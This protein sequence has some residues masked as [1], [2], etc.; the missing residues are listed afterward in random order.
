MTSVLKDNQKQNYLSDLCQV[1]KKK[2]YYELIFKNNE[3][4][5]LYIINDEIFRL[6]IQPKGREELPSR[7]QKSNKATKIILNYQSY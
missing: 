4:G 2:D 6:V 5:K 1:I 7:A 3:I